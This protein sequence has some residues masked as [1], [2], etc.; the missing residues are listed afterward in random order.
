MPYQPINRNFALK[1]FICLLVDEPFQLSEDAEFDGLVII[2]VIGLASGKV[3]HL[4][5]PEFPG[6]YFYLAWQAVFEV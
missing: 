2:P 4:K 6:S 3:V 5:T 1:K